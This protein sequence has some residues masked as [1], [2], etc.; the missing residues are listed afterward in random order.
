DRLRVAGTAEIAGYDLALTPG[1]VANLYAL[2]VRLYPAFAPYL[3]A[4]RAEAWAGLR[5]MSADGVGIMGPTPIS[6]LYLNTGHGPLGW[7][8]A[9]GAGRMVADLVAGRAPALDPAP[10]G[11]A[12]FG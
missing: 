3:D 7:T 5:P 4:A 10:Y 6:N 8:M 1:R 2:V 11:L 9:A 12:R